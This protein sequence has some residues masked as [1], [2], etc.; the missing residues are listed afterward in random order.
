MLKKILVPA[1]GSNLSM[2]SAQ[3]AVELARDVG[4]EVVGFIATPIYKMRVI[5]DAAFAPGTLSEADFNKAVKRSS[6]KY[7]D[8]IRKMAEVHG[9]PFTGQSV[10]SEKTAQAIVDAADQYACDLIFMG[11]HGRTCMAQ[12]FLGGVTTKVLSLSSVPVMVFRTTKKA[13]SKKRAR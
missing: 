2:E 7:L 12:I 10:A 5:E 3:A 4:A 11:S 13:V 8:E 6:K 1:D 9:V